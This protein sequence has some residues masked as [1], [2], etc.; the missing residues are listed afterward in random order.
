MIA[1][2]HGD[3]T[4]WPNLALAQLAGYFTARGE[5]V[6]LVRA[7]DRRDLWDRPRRVLGSSIFSFSEKTR[8]VIEREWGA[9]EWGGTGVRLDSN[10]SEVDGSA[11][12]D[13]IAPDL[14]V[15]PDFMASIGFTQRGCRL[16]CKFCVVPKK[17]GKPRAVRTIADIYRGKGF[18]K[19]ILLLDNDFFGQ[20]REEWEA[21][22]RELRDGGFRVCLAQGINV[23]QVDEDS[24]LALATLRYS[25][26]K[27]KR[28]R[29]YTAWDNLGD[30]DIVKRGVKVLENAGIP[31][32]HLMVYMLVGYAKGET[33]EEIL[34]RFNELAALGCLPY[35]MPFDRTR[36]DLR[37]FARWATTGL[38]RS[39]PW[40]AYDVRIKKARTA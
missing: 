34:Y 25:S 18:P 8:A 10:L 28:R 22:V 3:G 30:E 39:I 37:A 2:A 11:D 6:R 24:A 23:R 5:S 15:Y 26:T 35:P 40:E 14:S 7:G 27:F 4:K 16:S 38:Y 36:K 12:W 21:R 29:L 9:V 13:A 20:P 1:L 19:N 31:P 17:E 32:R 33:F